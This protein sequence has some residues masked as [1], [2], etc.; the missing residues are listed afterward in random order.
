MISK[1][2]LSPDHTKIAYTH[3]RTGCEDYEMRVLHIG[4]GEDVCT[5]IQGAYN[6][7]FDPESSSLLYTL[8]DKA[9]R[10]HAAHVRLLPGDT[11]EE[12]DV[13]VF[14]EKDEAFYV[15][16]GATKD[17]H[18][19]TVSSCSKTTTEV[20]LVNK[21]FLSRDPVIVSPR[22]HGLQYFVEHRKDNLYL[23]NNADEA[24]NF[25]ISITP[26]ESPSKGNWKT[27]VAARENGRI[28]DIDLM[29]D[30]LVVYE[31]VDGLPSMRVLQ[32]SETESDRIPKI[33]SDKKVAL[34]Y[35]IGTLTPGSNLE[36][37]ASTVSFTME[38]PVHAPYDYIFNLETGLTMEKRVDLVN[39]NSQ[40]V[41]VPV[42]FKDDYICERVIVRTVDKARVPMTV[43]RHRDTH[44]DGSAPVLISGYGA[45]GD[46]LPVV[47]EADRFPM[48]DEGWIF[49]LA[50]VRGGSE[51][52]HE[53]AANGRLMH[54]KN[55]FSDFIACAEWLIQN[56]Y[57]SIGKVVARGYSAGGLLVSAS[58]AQ[59]PQIFAG[60]ILNVP[61]VDVITAMSDS[62]LP[63]TVHER[64][65]WGDLRDPAVFKY[66][67]SYCPYWNIP[68]NHSLPP[69]LI[70]VALEDRRV[71]AAGPIKYFCK[72]RDRRSPVAHADGS[73]PTMDNAD[74]SSSAP[75]H[76][77]YGSGF[78]V[79]D[80]L[81]VHE[82]G[83]HFSDAMAPSKAATEM[84]FAKVCV[85][86]L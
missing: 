27:L 84:A 71:Q 80:L 49:A 59:K 77:S 47:F 69:M 38:S 12:D 41:S 74:N 6:A 3:D 64:D 36:P 83:G 10:P 65:E 4:T 61:F 68:E 28:E 18:V 39:I 8:I 50:H 7:T 21:D 48:M 2:I 44:L 72:L 17:L 54:K 43:V 32:L 75:T 42:S 56:Q 67:L 16:V 15:D 52:G 58:V 31:R 82:S 55:S 19:F 46:A 34:P 63:L 1:L 81:Y 24:K 57:T 25:Q 85:S 37:G 73:S 45:Y 5:P 13:K 70:S 23:V 22:I 29:Q 9:H 86:L 79:P 20:R 26:L 33:I 78:D 11:S 14:E 30:H 40:I 60:A 35:E 76:G 51:L 53:H 66:V 62:S